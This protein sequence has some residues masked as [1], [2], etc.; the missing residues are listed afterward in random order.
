VVHAHVP[1]TLYIDVDDPGILTDI[2]NLE[3]YQDLAQHVPSRGVQ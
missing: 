2:D 1:D 3:R